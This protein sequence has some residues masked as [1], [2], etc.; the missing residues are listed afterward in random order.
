[1]TEKQP[2]VIDLEQHDR[3][4][5]WLKAARA[6]KLAAIKKSDWKRVRFKDGTFGWM[7]KKTGDIRGGDQKPRD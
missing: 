3:G 6:A 5:H 4:P 7:H 2:I 1:M